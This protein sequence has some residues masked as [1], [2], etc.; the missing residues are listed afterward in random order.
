MINVLS[1]IISIAYSWIFFFSFAYT[2]LFPLLASRTAFSHVSLI[3]SFHQCSSFRLFYFN[4]PNVVLDVQS[5]YFGFNSPNI[6]PYACLYVLE[7]QDLLIAYD[8]RRH[9]IFPGLLSSTTFQRHQFRLS[10]SEKLSAIRLRTVSGRP[11][12][13]LSP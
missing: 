1:P 3:P 9:E 8:F 11:H 2:H 5:L 7:K 13:L 12:G 10:W 4:N 6:L